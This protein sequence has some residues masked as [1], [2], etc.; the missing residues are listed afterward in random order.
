LRVVLDTNV[1]VR[2]LLTPPN[3]SRALLD[4][5][6]EGPSG[7]LTVLYDTRILDEYRGVLRR[8]K[9]GFDEKRVVKIVR[10]LQR[11]GERVKIARR[12]AL[13]PLPDPK[14]APF[15]E[16]AAVGKAALVVTFNPKHYP[17]TLGFM[18]VDAGSTLGALDF[19]RGAG[20]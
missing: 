5:A 9:F 6:L 8:P 11:V 14:D 19:L 7:G 1:L 10:R 20:E 13:P 12:P 4:L 18:V 15:V 2:A 3:P 17:K 16:V